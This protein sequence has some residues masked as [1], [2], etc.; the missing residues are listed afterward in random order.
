MNDVLFVF[1]SLSVS[2]SILALI[3]LALKPLVKIKLSQTW[4]YY[5]WLIV[6]FRF[7]LPFTPQISVVGELSRYVQN[8]SNPPA[9]VEIDPGID[10]NEE[11]ANPQL[12]D[13][14]Q[15][16]Q[17]PVPQDVETETPA[18]PAY[19]RDILNNIWL[20]WIGVALVLFVHKVASYRGFA[21]F[22]KVGMK[23][24]TDTHIW[25]IYQSE[26]TAAKIKRQ[27]PLYVNAQAVSPML[28]G[29]VRPALVIPALEASD[30]E[31]RHIF[32]H[33]L[34][35]Y[36]RLD[37]L[38]KWIVQIVLCLHWFNPLVY[39]INRQISKSCE[40]SCD[41]AVIKHLDESD[42]T[43]Y[44]DALI[45]SLKAQ[46][47]YSD[48]VV[49]MTMSENGNIVKERLDMIMCY[50]KKSKLTVICS[51]ILSAIFLCCAMFTGAYAATTTKP[52]DNLKF[53][54]N[55]VFNMSDKLHT[56]TGGYQSNYEF[57]LHESATIRIS[58]KITTE[59]GEL[60][61]FIQQLGDENHFIN[62][63]AHD[64]NEVL[65]KT[66]YET[67][68]SNI[69]ETTDVFL[70]A[71]TY[72]MSIQGT[73]TIRNADWKIAGTIV[74]GGKPL[75][76]IYANSNNMSYNERIPT[77]KVDAFT[78]ELIQSNKA[79]DTVQPFLPYM[80]SN[81]AAKLVE[82][83]KPWYRPPGVEIYLG[84]GQNTY[85]NEPLT[86]EIVN[87][88]A[89]D[90]IQ[91]TGNWSYVKPMFPYMTADAVK[92]VAEIYISKT[93]RYDI[94]QEA[95][96]YYEGELEAKDESV[97][98]TTD[99]NGIDFVNLPNMTSKE[100]DALA[101]SYIDATG[102][103]GYVYNMCPYMSTAGIDASVTAY[104]DKG[105]DIGIVGAML[106]NMSREAA[107]TI[108]QKYYKE[109]SNDDY[110]WIFKPYL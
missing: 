88:H 106:P 28:V 71:G 57:I 76:Q 47:N 82:I 48:F 87:N 59:Q 95:S 51:F 23:T 21:R 60:T 103:F 65:R 10:M 18:Q 2:G 94:A 101:L 17:A 26:L 8:I 83:V 13:A 80:T 68:G 49:S 77:D 12:P 85:S 97:Q 105:G 32:R 55:Q 107:R 91:N 19:W 70:E 22:I 90:V 73:G 79:W 1:L 9:V 3:L 44:G 81:N 63:Y 72:Y 6:I 36:K 30:D 43:I 14:P 66:I 62:G 42:R 58:T 74:I 5:I 41:E 38:Y 93:G 67:K 108:A 4:Q 104:L 25:D 29:I 11:Y 40:L 54:D 50:R 99:Y 34:T 45:A 92:K 75:Q 52:T 35:H 89:C 27:L 56:A 39:L 96:P 69:D 15:V 37:F 24:L 109:K 84:A 102:Q 20:L 16:L 110:D 46:G 86:R 31:L 33:E 98:K 61:C 100:V 78:L 7:L 53:M 64:R